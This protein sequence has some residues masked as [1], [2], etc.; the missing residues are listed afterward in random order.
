[1]IGSIVAAL[2]GAAFFVIGLGALLA[3][4]MSS[5]AYGLPTTDRAALALVRAVGAR[6]LVL[7]I[8]VL[9]LLA[10][11]NRSALQIV[12]FVSIL[13]AAGDATAVATG[14][15]DAGPQHLSVHFSG[16]AALL[17]AALLVRS[18]R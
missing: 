10:S 11:R 18:G 16:A 3:P 7:G 9:L 17:V 14:R 12:L 13:A 6:D 15:E 2:G 8:I 5:V 1:M 4:G